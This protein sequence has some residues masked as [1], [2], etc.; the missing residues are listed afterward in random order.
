M[1]RF[2]IRAG[3]LS[4]VVALATMLQAWPSAAQ[5]GQQERH[6]YASDKPLTEARIFAEGIVSTDEHEDSPGF[7]RDGKTIYWEYGQ[8]VLSTIVYSRF[9]R[10]R[11]SEP[12]VAEFSGRYHDRDPFITPDGKRLYFCS[13]RPAPGSTE[14]RRDWDIWYV[15]QT[16]GGKWGPPVRLAAPVNTDF[17]ELYAT[18]TTTGTLYFGSVRSGQWDLYRARPANETYGEPERLSDAVNSTAWDFNPEISPDE[19]FLLFSSQRAG[20]PGQINIY[21]S[22]NRNGEWTQARLLSEAVNKKGWQ[23]HPTLSPDGKY[24]FF[25]G[26][27]RGLDDTTSRR[28][29]TYRD[30]MKGFRSLHNR[31]GNIYQIELRAAGV[32]L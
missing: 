20:G 32:E 11:W 13:R 15:E 24:L 10:G 25:C 26:G 27:G 30:L 2:R 8:P 3:A 22:Y 18:L 12:Q 1:K 4:L 6:P 19:R 14:A 17:D 29:V 7:S 16:A 9:E 23:Y 5:Q 31:S 21:V 28:P